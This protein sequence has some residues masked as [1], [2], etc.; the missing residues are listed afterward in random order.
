MSAAG[1]IR[2]T[3]DGSLLTVTL[4]RPEVRNALTPG[5][6]ADLSEVFVSANDDSAVRVVLLRAEGDRVFCAGYDIRSI[7]RKTRASFEP[8]EA[9][10]RVTDAITSCS[11][12][13]IAAIHGDCIGAACDLVL[14]CDLR[15]AATEARFAVPVARIGGVYPPAGVWRFLSVLG[16]P[17]VQDLL[18]TGEYVDAPRARELGLVQRVIPGDNFVS[19]TLQLAQRIAENA[20][21]SLAATKQLIRNMTVRRPELDKQEVAALIERVRMS[22]DAEEGLQAA[23]ERRAPRFN[24]R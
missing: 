8:G 20:P 17:G 18:L 12:P 9:M 23:T 13:V 3:L 5:M 2:T 19:Q 15:V 4:A 10:D 24:R 21:L 1:S 6:L 11:R 22:E 16:K 14:A 7:P